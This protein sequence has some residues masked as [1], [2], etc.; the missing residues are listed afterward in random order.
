M[1][2]SL[3]PS[4]RYTRWRAVRNGF[5][6]ARAAGHAGRAGLGDRRG[7]EAGRPADAE[8][9]AADLRWVGARLEQF[10]P[11]P[12][13]MIFVEQAGGHPDAFRESAFINGPDVPEVRRFKRPSA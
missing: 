9:A 7:R 5:L 2:F 8:A 11:K 6:G 1:K 4:M 10:G 12:P 3:S 13:R